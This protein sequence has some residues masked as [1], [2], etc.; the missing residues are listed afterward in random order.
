MKFFV[1]DIVKAFPSIYGSRFMTM[2]LVKV[3]GTNYKSAPTP[4][5]FTIAHKENADGYPLRDCLCYA[6][7]KEPTEEE[8]NAFFEKMLEL[9]ANEAAMLKAEGYDGE[10]MFTLDDISVED[11]DIIDGEII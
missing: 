1:V 2:D 9:T 5:F 7:E 4:G 6:I 3:L 11:L 8:K 10:E